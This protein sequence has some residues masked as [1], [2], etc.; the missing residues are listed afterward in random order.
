MISSL[1]LLPEISPFTFPWLAVD[2]DIYDVLEKY[3]APVECRMWSCGV[4]PSVVSAGDSGGLLHVMMAALTV[5]R[6]EP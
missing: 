5:S 1:P 4:R 3:C 2:G 6:T